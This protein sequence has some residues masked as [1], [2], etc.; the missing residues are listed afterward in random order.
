MIVLFV[1]GIVL[2][3]YAAIKGVT[4]HEVRWPALV[5]GLILTVLMGLG[6][7]R[8]Q[9]RHFLM[10]KVPVEKTQK[11]APALTINGI[12]LITTQKASDGELR[13]TYTLGKK[14]YQT[15]PKMRRQSSR[16][17]TNKRR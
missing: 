4:R 16:R 10:A 7:Q 1:L 14:S 12:K 17:R 9:E 11:I 15:V 5:V 13:Y 6:L 8:A 3:A 2:L